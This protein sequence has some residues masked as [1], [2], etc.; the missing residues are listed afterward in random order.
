MAKWFGV[1]GY[2]KQ[3]EDKPGIWVEQIIEKQYY[4]ELT[5]NVRKLQSSGFVNDD[6]AVTNEI[7]IIADPFANQNFHSI[8]F[9]E[10]MGTRWKVSNVEVLYP[11]LI[12]SIGGQYNG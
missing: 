6:I 5:R 3:V 4:G 9:V 11:R 1:I 8:R 12:L 10:F 2:A 7:S